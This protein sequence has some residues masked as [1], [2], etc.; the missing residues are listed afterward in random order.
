[1][2]FIIKYAKLGGVF[3]AAVILLAFFF[4]LLNLIGLSYKITSILIII[5]MVI[6]FLIFGIIAGI[7]AS[8][9]GFIEG[10]KIGLLFLGLLVIL[11][12]IL[13]KTPFSLSRI[14]YYIILVFSSV[15]GAMIGINR[16][17]KD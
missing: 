4:G 17:K 11:N 16:K 6:V 12:L 8:K 2:K 3:L 15:F 10:L 9:K 1:M 14:I 13:F 7:N 5:A